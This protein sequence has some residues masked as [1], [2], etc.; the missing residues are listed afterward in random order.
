MAVERAINMALRVLGIGEVERDFKRVGAAGDQAFGK[1]AKAANGADK[2]VSEYTRRLRNAVAAAK[3]AVD[4][5]PEFQAQRVMDPEGY[6]RD[7][8][9]TIMAAVGME[10]NAMREGL[11]ETAAA[12]DSLYQSSDKAGMSMKS[13]ALLGTAAATA[14]GAAAKFVWDSA[15]AYMEHEQA[16]DS[17]YATLSLGGN[18][19][20]SA[21]SEIEAMAGR[22][23]D[24]TNQTEEAALQAAASLAKV[25]D[26]TKAGLD[27]A[28]NV[29][30]LLADAL[31][32]DVTDVVEDMR[33]V[34][35]ALAK[36]D[37]KALY[38]A[39]EDLNDPLRVAIMNLAETGKTAEAQKVYLDGLRMAAGTGPNGL[40]TAANELSDKWRDLLTAFGEDNSGPAVAML[41]TLSGWLD[42]FTEK[43]RG[44]IR[45][46]KE[47]TL[48]RGVRQEQ[49][50]LD[51]WFASDEQRATARSRQT[52][53]KNGL[54]RMRGQTDRSGGF[55]DM[56]DEPTWAINPDI[57]DNTNVASQLKGLEARYG[58]SAS[59]GGGGGRGR[60]GKSD[61]EREADRLKREAE[62]AREAADRVIESND[63]VIASYLIR[64]QEAEEKTGLEGA[65]LK[66]V[67]RSHAIEAA[68]RRINRDEIER[69]V[70][71]RRAAAQMADE[72]FDETA[73]TREATAAVEAKAEQLRKLAAREI[74]AA[75]ATAE[76]NRKQAEAARIADMVK[77]PLEQLTEEIERAIEA[78]NG[79]AI[80]DDQFNRRMDQM[81]ESLAD[82][83]Y[84]ADKSAHAWRGYGDDV[85]R[86]LSDLALNGGN[87]RDVL[88][89]LI[90]MPLE[91]L[92]Y[93][94][95]EVPVANFIDGLTG[96]N[97][98]K[99]V[100]SARADL[101]IAGDA[102]AGSLAMVGTSGLQAAQAL[103]AVALG[104]GDD[105]SQL[106]ATAIGTGESLQSVEV[107]LHDFGNSLLSVITMLASGGGGG[108]GLS[109]LLGIGIKAVAGSIGGGAGATGAY[110]GYGDGTNMTGGIMNF[111]SGTDRLP[112]ERPF[113]VG[114]NGRELMELTRGGGMRV[115][116]NQQSH[117]MLGEGGGGTTL[118]QTINIPQGADPRRT[119]SAVNRATQT[120]LARTARKGL[121]G[122]IDR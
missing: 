26:L 12:W 94:N 87:A 108:G 2:E 11:G 103:N 6:R 38:E 98:E 115:H 101:P 51:S 48:E 27:E 54:A 90:R 3:G 37:M 8:N 59:K 79:G 99:N 82:I 57:V 110:A 114:E 7:R 111:A 17:F 4:R 106:G 102:A 68:A 76:F 13:A 70:A 117:R 97:R 88:Q 18:R 86:T 109:G 31:G 60:S 23:V 62:Q 22:V 113:W 32:T 40:T 33:P 15:Q 19:T 107:G 56:R 46:W 92:L 83:R 10:Q 71:A 119:A 78:L 118:V 24:A 47:W 91:R 69:E 120:G 105:L 66:A 58:G 77:T 67:E 21:A 20:D 28:L 63:D 14:I 53:F 1:V 35:E 9:Q 80:S 34:L 75:A 41:R 61:A 55:R 116:S 73:A 5:S 81:A 16:V 122:G 65:A 96:N 64:A 30:A 85:G 93:Q 104:A 89:E 112:I 72:T 29:A 84:E 74:D 44:A 121:A 39:T 100:A 43:T 25:P 49:M 45:W 50:V 52:Q 95:F 36:K 42:T